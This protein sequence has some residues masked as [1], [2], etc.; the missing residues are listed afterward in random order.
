MIQGWEDGGMKRLQICMFNSDFYLQQVPIL[1]LEVNVKKVQLQKSTSS[2][3]KKK[4]TW[5]KM[6]FTW[7]LLHLICWC[8]RL[9]QVPQPRLTLAETP[10][11]SRFAPLQVLFINYSTTH[12]G[13]V[14]SAIKS[15]VVPLTQGLNND[16]SYGHRFKTN[17]KKKIYRFTLESWDCLKALVFYVSLNF[18]QKNCNKIF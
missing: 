18:V 14:S 5:S 16:Y 3:L 7:S 8:S 2:N 9:G 15:C 13:I 4:L 6:T 1:H 10:P 17:Q 11:Q 12:W